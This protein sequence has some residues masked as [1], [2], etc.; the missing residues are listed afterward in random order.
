MCPTIFSWNNI[1]EILLIDIYL[2]LTS[3]RMSCPFSQFLLWVWGFSCIHRVEMR[4]TSG[5]RLSLGLSIL[6]FS[7]LIRWICLLLF[8][9]SFPHSPSQSWTRTFY[10]GLRPKHWVLC[11]LVTFLNTFYCMTRANLQHPLKLEEMSNIWHLWLL[12]STLFFSHHSI[13]FE[14]FL[15]S[16]QYKCNA[17]LCM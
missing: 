8:A 6:S 9:G 10:T 1:R 14:A 15:K 11:P 3:D 4:S 12:L 16:E 17:F 7:A 2:S 5:Y 13:Y